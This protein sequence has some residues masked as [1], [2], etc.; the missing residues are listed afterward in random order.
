VSRLLQK[1]KWKLKEG[2]VT[3]ADKSADNDAGPQNSQ[4]YEQWNENLAKKFNVMYKNYKKFQLRF[5][6]EEEKATS[7]P[8]PEAELQTPGERKSLLIDGK[9]TVPVSH[10]IR[11]HLL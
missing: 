9:Y 1:N 5:M 11:E 4:S 7:I 2:A 10:N 6:K 3:A 8:D